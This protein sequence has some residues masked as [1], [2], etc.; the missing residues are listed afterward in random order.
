MKRIV[1]LFVMVFLLIGCSSEEEKAEQEFKESTT[2]A[3]FVELNSDEK[4][5]KEKAVH[6]TG[7]ITFVDGGEFVVTTDEKDGGKGMYEV[8]MD[9]N[10][11]LYK[12]EKGKKVTVY[13]FYT[14]KDIS[15]GMP[16]ITARYVEDK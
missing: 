11:P 1:L 12:G 14:G 8:V 2:K 6:F 5:N 7:E 15:T 13:G 9:S 10:Y 16:N 4:A 3:D